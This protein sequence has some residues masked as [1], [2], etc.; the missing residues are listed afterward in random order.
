MK[1]HIIILKSLHKY[2]SFLLIFLMWTISAIIYGQNNVGINA[3]GTKPDPSAQLDVSSSTQGFLLPQ[4]DT[5]L[6]NSYCKKSGI[7]IAISLLM[8]QLSNNTFYYY[9]DCKINNKLVYWAPL[10]DGASGVTGPTGPTGPTGF[11]GP[12]GPTAAGTVTSITGTANQINVSSGTSKAVISL[13]STI[14]TPGTLTVNST[15]TGAFIVQSTT[16]TTIFSVDT[17]TPKINATAGIYFAASSSI[18]AIDLTAVNINSPY[19]DGFGSLHFPNA[20]TG[21]TWAVSDSSA[22]VVL[23][24]NVSGLAGTSFLY[25]GNVNASTILNLFGNAGNGPGTVSIRGSNDATTPLTT[26]VTNVNGGGSNGGTLNLLGGSNATATNNSVVIGDATNSGILAVNS[27]TTIKATSTTAL[28][29]ES[30]TPTTILTVDTSTPKVVIGTSGTN[31][32]INFGVN[33]VADA[34]SVFEFSVSVTTT[35]NATYNISYPAG[36]SLSNIRFMQAGVNAG[37]TFLVPN[38]FTSATQL[39]S[40]YAAANISLVTGPSWNVSGPAYIWVWMT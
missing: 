18:H 25:G 27:T 5:V 7:P 23:Q 22:T 3:T 2:I 6:I 24:V 14:I 35:S 40:I 28:V 39:Y 15:S 12:I 19:M 31:V 17:S 4:S 10:G 36:K 38:N 1:L 16:P 21:A 33:G 29:V 34:V 8:Y 37:G 13:S 32:P 20:S 9:C 11:T 30:A 26:N